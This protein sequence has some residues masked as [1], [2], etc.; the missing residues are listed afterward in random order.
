MFLFAVS[1]GLTFCSSSSQN[2][3]CTQS[4][5]NTNIFRG[6]TIY[7]VVGRY[8]L[9]F[10]KTLSS[11]CWSVYAGYVSRCGTQKLLLVKEYWELIKHRLLFSIACEEYVQPIIGYS[12]HCLW[13]AHKQLL[14]FLNLSFPHLRLACQQ[15]IS[16]FDFL[17]CHYFFLQS[18]NLLLFWSQQTKEICAILGQERKHGICDICYLNAS[19]KSIED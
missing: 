2:Q 18:R 15:T 13:F 5:W 3:N 19:L 11:G 9:W 16:Y 1:P 8:H 6:G 10:G 4:L 7:S 17:Q 14:S 12:A